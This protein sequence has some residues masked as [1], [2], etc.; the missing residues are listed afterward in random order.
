MLQPERLVLK[1]RMSGLL[2][3]QCIGVCD[4]SGGGGCRGDGGASIITVRLILTA[5]DRMSEQTE[6]V[7]SHQYWLLESLAKRL[8]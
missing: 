1:R 4:C 3:K 8:T 2:A 6:G 7:T 5:L